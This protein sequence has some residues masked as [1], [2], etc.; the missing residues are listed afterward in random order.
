MKSLFLFMKNFYCPGW[1][2]SAGDEVAEGCFTVT[3]PSMFFSL[4]ILELE[5]FTFEFSIFR[6]IFY[7]QSRLEWLDI[8]VEIEELTEV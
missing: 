7:K 4:K 6:S 5:I 1:C 3:L 2:D 8:K